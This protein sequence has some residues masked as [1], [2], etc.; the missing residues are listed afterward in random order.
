MQPGADRDLL[1]LFALNVAALAALAALPL[2]DIETAPYVI[3][4]YAAAYT[5]AWLPAS[6]CYARAAGIAGRVKWALV[7]GPPL[8]LDAFVAASIYI[9]TTARPIAAPLLNTPIKPNGHL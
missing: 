1:Y 3:A 7:A 5:A 6:L 2:N 9:L 4:G 8:V